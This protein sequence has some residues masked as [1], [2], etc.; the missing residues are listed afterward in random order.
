M[1][2]VGLVVAYL[3]LVAAAFAAEVTL[4]S[5]F[6]GAIAWQV[7][8]AP[9]VVEGFSAGLVYGVYTIAPYY[10]GYVYVKGLHVVLVNPNPLPTEVVLLGV[11]SWGLKPLLDVAEVYGVVWD[12]GRPEGVELVEGPRWFPDAH[13]A[14]YMMPRTVV[15]LTIPLPYG[16]PGELLACTPTGCVRVQSVAASYLRQVK[17]SPWIIE[18]EPPSPREPVVLQVWEWHARTLGG[19]PVPCYAWGPPGSY[20]RIL[21]CIVPLCCRDCP[22]GCTLS[23]AQPPWLMRSRG[24]CGVDRGPLESY[25]LAS[26][27]PPHVIAG[28]F[29]SDPSFSFETPREVVVAGYRYELYGLARSPGSTTAS[30]I[31]G[32]WTNYE[33]HSCFVREVEITL[34]AIPYVPDEE[35]KQTTF[36]KLWKRSKWIYVYAAAKGYYTEWEW[37]LLPLF[38][39]HPTSVTQ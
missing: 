9:R 21:C 36:R 32:G 12:G 23:R 27:M 1:R 25:S 24:V 4:V 8:Q 38:T 17:S 20:M 30:I 26:G 29:T 34:Y 11:Y 6:T 22:P 13:L 37:F 3:V 5:V 31:P 10:V 16:D 15:S 39:I 14:L 7:L 28:Y 2:T 33:F 19:P 18:E 35:E